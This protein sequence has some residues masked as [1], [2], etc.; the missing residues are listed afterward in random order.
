MTRP[1]G[2]QP[3]EGDFGAAYGPPPGA[4]RPEPEGASAG[5]RSLLLTTRISADD[6]E[7]ETAATAL[8]LFGE[9]GVPEG[10]PARIL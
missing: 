9:E 7:E 8:R 10:V 1:R 3:P 4:P 6:D 2:P 5:G